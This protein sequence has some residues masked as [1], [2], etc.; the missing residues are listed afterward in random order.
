MDLANSAASTVSERPSF[1]DLMCPCSWHPQAIVVCH[2]LVVKHL[3]RLVGLV[4]IHTGRERRSLLFP[5]LPLDHLPVDLPRSPR[6]TACRSLRCSF[7]RWKTVDRYAAGSC[8]RCGMRR[9]SPRR[10]ALSSAAL[11]RGCFRNS[12]R[13][14]STGEFPLLLRCPFLVALAADIRHTPGRH[15]RMRILDRHDVVVAMAVLAA[16]GQGSPLA[17]ALPCS[18]SACCFCSSAWQDPQ[19]T[20][21][22]FSSWGR[23]FFSRSAW[24]AVHP[25]LP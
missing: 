19:A 15:G 18:D 23:S 12:S 22:R 3:A 9:T 8:G 25:N 24:H 4:A 7:G 20:G 17:T 2:P 10:P 1:D 13:G 6:G 14:Y 5:Q 21:A 16:R 11:R